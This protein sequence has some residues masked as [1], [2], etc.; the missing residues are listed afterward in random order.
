MGDANLLLILFQRDAESSLFAESFLTRRFQIFFQ[1]LFS[2][3]KDG[4]LCVLDADRS[5]HRKV[6]LNPPGTRAGEDSQEDY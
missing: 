3:C 6:C 4:S 1:L 5:L 2:L